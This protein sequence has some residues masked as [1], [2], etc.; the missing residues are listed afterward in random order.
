LAKQKGQASLDA[1]PAIT[2]EEIRRH[3]RKI[4]ADIAH[5]MFAKFQLQEDEPMVTS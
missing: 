1:W 2:C 4:A 3:I 5:A